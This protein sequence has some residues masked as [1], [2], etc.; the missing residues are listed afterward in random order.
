M[1]RS[2]EGH[3]GLFA[4]IRSAQFAMKKIVFCA[5]LA[6]LG[7]P[8]WACTPAF[9]WRQVSFEEAGLTAL[10]PCKPEHASRAL[11]LAGQHLAAKMVACQAGGAMF[12]VVLMKLESKSLAQASAVAQAAQASSQAAQNKVLK[13]EHFVAQ[14]S[15]YGQAAQGLDG[16]GALST[17]VAQTF[18]EHFSLKEAQ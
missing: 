11:A 4:H 1:R 12:T 8:Q 5:L 7:M 9:N 18:F 14:A 10:L 16:P 2:N 6:L 17:Q 3:I 15:I 13:T